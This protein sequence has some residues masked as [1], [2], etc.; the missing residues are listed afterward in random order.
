M[1]LLVD[2]SKMLVTVTR[3]AVDKVDQNGVP[4]TDRKTGLSLKVVQVMVLESETGAEILNVTVAGE[5]PKV[6][7]GQAVVL[8]DLEAI[9][10][11][12]NGKN[13]VA[14]RAKS[15]SPATAL[16]SKAA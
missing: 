7:V 9:P 11:A 16:H 10:W 14:F 4:K 1:K 3:E 15:I 12:T 6:T 5:P 8:V 2:T 13:G